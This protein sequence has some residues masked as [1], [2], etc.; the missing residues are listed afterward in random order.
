MSANVAIPQ[1]KAGR[2]KP[3]HLAVLVI[4][5]AIGTGLAVFGNLVHLEPIASASYLAAGIM[6]VLSMWFGGWG[7]LAQAIGVTLG[8]IIADMPIP[9]SLAFTIPLGLFQG[10]LPAM[11]VRTL[12][13]DPTLKSKRDWLIFVGV[14]V[15]INVII[16]DVFISA[17]LAT[18][19]HWPLQVTFNADFPLK[20]LL[21]ILTFLIITAA[22]CKGLS[23]YVGRTRFY[24][25]G[26]WD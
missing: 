20:I 14:V 22:L 6:S 9:I 26:W 21:D 17:G 13:M 16:S 19:N 5:S 10:F 2:I 24:N 7:V 4:G 8:G 15:L 12:K 25:K 23:G 3:Q 18:Y 1:T 11:A